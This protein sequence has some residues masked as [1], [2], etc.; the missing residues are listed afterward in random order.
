[1]DRGQGRK[2]RTVSPERVH[3]HAAGGPRRRPGASGAG[4]RRAVLGERGAVTAEIAV[5][6]PAL[7]VLLA[8]LLGTA[9]VGTVQLRIEEAARAGAREAVRGESSDAVEQTVQ[10]LAGANTTTRVGHAAGWITVEVRAEVD[11]PLVGL[12]GITLEATASGKDE[13]DGR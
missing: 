1:M 11:A 3:T 10:R 2:Q 9:H 7:V 13:H 12:L 6:L 8:L 5:V 4:Y